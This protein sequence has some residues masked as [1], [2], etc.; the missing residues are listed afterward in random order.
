MGMFLTR[1]AIGIAEERGLDLIEVAPN[2]NPPV[3]KIGDYGRMMYEKKKKD[4]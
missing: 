4:F 2:A 3:C 1:D